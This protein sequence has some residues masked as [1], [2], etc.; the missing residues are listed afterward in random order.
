MAL[1]TYSDL[2]NTIQGWVDREDP[3][4]I[5]EI[6]S[7]IRLAES[8][9]YRDLRCRDNE[10]IAYY[11]NTDYGIVGQAGL[12]IPPV[13]IH[14]IMPSNYKEV[15]L[16]TW[17]DTPLQEI[18]LQNLKERRL[19]NRDHLVQYFA[20]F[21]RTMDFSGAI[22]ED[23]SLWSDGQKLELH[24]Y[25]T[26]SLDS[27]PDWH[28]VDNPVENPPIE[29][30]TTPIVQSDANTTRMFQHHPEMYLHGALHFAYFFLQDYEKAALYKP[31]FFEA[32]ERVRLESHNDL[33]T[34]STAEV[35]SVYG[36]DSY[37]G[38]GR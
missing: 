23:P 25:G 22:E 16:V 3:E 34:G 17:D 10:F 36:D 31:L 32:T 5:A 6:P 7:F 26:E 20:H 29:A 30:G 27:L 11:T 19:F 1:E 37:Y 24:Y 28:T 15:N 35:T 13:G 18:S 9:I 8:E 14:R 4:F 33:F 21:A 2:K 12:G 38:G